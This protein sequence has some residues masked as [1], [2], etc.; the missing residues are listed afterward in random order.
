MGVAKQSRLR[1]ADALRDLR[2]WACCASSGYGALMHDRYTQAERN[3]YG[4]ADDEEMDAILAAIA[5]E[6]DKLP[7]EQRRH[8]TG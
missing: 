7:E 8:Y 5:K 4:A 2:C 3:I 1:V 6:L